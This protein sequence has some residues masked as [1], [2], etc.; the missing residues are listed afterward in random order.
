MLI[1]GIARQVMLTKKALEGDI[2]SFRISEQLQPY[3]Q[4]N[5]LNMHLKTG[6]S[7]AY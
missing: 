4:F 6:F 3:S 5:N 1:I 2:W 7:F